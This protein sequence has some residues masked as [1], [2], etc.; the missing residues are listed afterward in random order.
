LTKFLLHVIQGNGI[1]DFKVS[2][3]H[4]INEHLFWETTCLERPC[5]IGKICEG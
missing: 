1:T 5:F 2:R 3:L 4:C